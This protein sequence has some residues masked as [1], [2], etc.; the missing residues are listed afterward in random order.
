MTQQPL[1]IA[2][3]CTAP[4]TPLEHPPQSPA[5]TEFRWR[6]TSAQA[7]QLTG[8][9]VYECWRCCLHRSS[10]RLAGTDLPDSIAAALD[11]RKS[12]TPVQRQYRIVLLIIIRFTSLVIVII[13][14]SFIAT[15]LPPLPHFQ[16]SL[17]ASQY[18]SAG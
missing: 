16:I 8:T 3:H 18:M 17:V 14:L 7:V 2:A 13:Q 11:L 9:V 12:T 15:F 1:A 5:P 6:S 4:G 10:N